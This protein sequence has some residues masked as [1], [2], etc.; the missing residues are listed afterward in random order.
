M[1]DLRIR[2]SNRPT[3]V[4]RDCRAYVYRCI[5]T[6][7]CR[8]I[9]SDSLERAHR[10]FKQWAEEQGIDLTWWVLQPSSDDFSLVL[11]YDVLPR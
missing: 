10:Y 5:D 11:P 2:S 6:G 9:I 1:I 4:P 8:V 3:P 7:L